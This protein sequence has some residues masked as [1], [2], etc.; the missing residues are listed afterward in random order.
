MSTITQAI[1][2]F[3]SNFVAFV[4]MIILAIVSFFFVVFVVDFGA[5]LAGYGGDEYVVLSSAL[6]VAAAILAGGISPLSDLS[7]ST[8]TTRQDAT[9]TADD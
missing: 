1:G 4:L 3:V 5:S 2:D 9:V 6:L 7:G 8:E